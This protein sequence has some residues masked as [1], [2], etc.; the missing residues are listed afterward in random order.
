MEIALIPNLSDLEAVSFS[1][2]RV[3]NEPPWSASEGNIAAGGFC[4]LYFEEGSR[5]IVRRVL[6]LIA[7]YKLWSN[8]P[9]RVGSVCHWFWLPSFWTPRSWRNSQEPSLNESWGEAE[10][11]FSSWNWKCAIKVGRRA[12][13]CAPKTHVRLFTAAGWPQTG[14]RLN[15]HQQNR[16]M[17][18]GIFIHTEEY[19]KVRKKT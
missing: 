16:W 3:W 2:S 10:P 9:P 5:Q 19:E 1:R 15:V 12:Q 7:S 6:P 18:C 17:N 8:K 11:T 4:W 14:N 13:A